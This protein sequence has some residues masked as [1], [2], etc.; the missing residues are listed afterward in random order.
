MELPRE[1]ALWVE[2]KEIRAKDV[3]GRW[4]YSITIQFLDSNAELHHLYHSLSPSPHH[5][6][7]Q[8][9]V[10]EMRMDMPETGLFVLF[11]LSLPLS[12]AICIISPNQAI[13]KYDLTLRPLAHKVKPMPLSSWQVSAFKV[14][15]EGSL[16]AGGWDW[17]PDWDR[18]WEQDLEQRAFSHD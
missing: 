7:L 5:S 12:P 18:R 11:L 13:C 6:L 16:R 14:P 10:R 8:D 1:K 4:F 17:G 2:W 9:T 15:R 3:R